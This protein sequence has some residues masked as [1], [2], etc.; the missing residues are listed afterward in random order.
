MTTFKA[1]IAALA[2]GLVLAPSGA[3]ASAPVNPCALL[4]LAEAQSITHFQLKSS[5]PNPLR[6]PNG[7]DKTTG[8]TYLSSD[9]SKSVAVIAHDDA[10][11]FPGNAKD[12]NTTGYTPLKG[13]AQRAWVQSTALTS[14]VYLLKNGKYVGIMV[15]DPAAMQSRGRTA[16]EAAIKV[17]KLVAGRM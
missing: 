9:E 11:Y 13:V 16:M 8:C 17:A 6:A 10:A 3:R 1:G 2:F 15:A 14:A 4:S 12:R 5:D 7:D